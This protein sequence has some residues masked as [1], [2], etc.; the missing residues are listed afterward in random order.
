MNILI[1]GAAGFIGS[2][3]ADYFSKNHSVVGLDNFS[4]SCGYKGDY[5]IVYG[6]VRYLEDLEVCIEN[7]DIVFHLAAQI[8]VDKSI[9]HPQET[10]DIN[11]QGTK[12]VLDLCKRY[13]KKVVFASTSEIYGGHKEKINEN[14]QTFAQSPY[15]IA[16]LG[17]EKLCQNY[18]DLYGVKTY[19]LRC[20]NTFGPRQANGTFGAVIPIFADMIRNDKQPIIFG[21]GEQ[22]RDYIYVSDVVR[23]YDFVTSI[24]ELQGRPINVATGISHSINDITNSINVILEKDIKPIYG[25]KRPGEVC[26]LEADI[27]LISSYGWKP[28]V[29]FED[30][31]RRYLCQLS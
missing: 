15:A 21:D 3:L 31:L 13:D 18:H 29:S 4:H 26:K 12:N 25:E 28:E 6:D 1:T 27:S 5:P 10:L 14:S 11:L 22:R 20:F 9:Q 17:A 23:A 24:P 19:I 7:C 30:G 16:K 8:N 2:H